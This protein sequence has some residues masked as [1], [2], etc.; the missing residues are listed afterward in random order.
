MKGIRIV[1]LLNYVPYSKT[2]AMKV[3]QDELGWQSYGGKHHESR[4][5]GFVHSYVHPVKFG[6]DY[7]KAT[8][9]TQIC[10]GEAHARGG[11]QLLSVNKAEQAAAD[12][13]TWRRSWIEPRGVRGDP[14]AAAETTGDYPTTSASW[15]S[16]TGCTAAGSGS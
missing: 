16:S 4:I 9:S 8:L 12:R 1:Y 7:R 2:S 11:A 14:V 10:A 15:S 5:T 3:L 13:R 6:I